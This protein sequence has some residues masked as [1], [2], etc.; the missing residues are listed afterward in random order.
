MSNINNEENSFKEGEVDSDNI[1][2]LD[3]DKFKL[4]ELLNLIKLII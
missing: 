3:D 4:K 1:M 2:E